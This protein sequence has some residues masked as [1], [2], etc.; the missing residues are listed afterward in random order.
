[1]NDK[2]FTMVEL[3]VTASVISILAALSIAQFEEYRGQSYDS[4]AY[5]QMKNA[6]TAVVAHFIDHPD[7][8]FESKGISIAPSGRNQGSGTIEEILPGFVHDADAKVAVLVIIRG[9]QAPWYVQRGG[10]FDIGVATCKGKTFGTSGALTLKRRWVYWSLPVFDMES[11][12]SFSE[13][14]NCNS[15][16]FFIP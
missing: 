8:N 4:R 13:A 14:L 7:V 15:D 16:E 9:N 5:L 11:E 2:A 6:H 3:L 10:S 1:M 12:Y